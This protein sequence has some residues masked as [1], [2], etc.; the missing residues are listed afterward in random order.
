MAAVP[1]KRLFTCTGFRGAVRQLVSHVCALMPAA[2][3]EDALSLAQWLVQQKQEG[4]GWGR[5]W[6]GQEVGIVLL[7][8]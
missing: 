6:A 3:G 1:H 4:G 2:A 7:S 8:Y 5:K